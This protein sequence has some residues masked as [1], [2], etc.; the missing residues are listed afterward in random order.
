MTRTH[1][2]GSGAAGAAFA[3]LYAVVLVQA[4]CTLLQAAQPA[5]DPWSRHARRARAPTIAPG[6]QLIQPTGRARQPRPAPRHRTIGPE[7]AVARH[8]SIFRLFLIEKPNMLPDM[9]FSTDYGTGKFH[10][11][12]SVV[13]EWHASKHG[14]LFHAVN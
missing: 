1:R 2:L 10:D 6:D 13:Y 9:E 7:P 3:L 11:L 4:V 8:K 12:S 5:T 14:T